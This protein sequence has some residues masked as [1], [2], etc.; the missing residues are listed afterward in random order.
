MAAYGEVLGAGLSKTQHAMLQ[1]A[2]SF[3]TWRTLVRGSGLE[4]GTAVRAMI[5]AI[6]CAKVP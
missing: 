3:F 4:Q 5:Q 1:L 6:D 2:L